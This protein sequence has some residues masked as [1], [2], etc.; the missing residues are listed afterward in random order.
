MVTQH[1]LKAPQFRPAPACRQRGRAPGRCTRLHAISI[2]LWGL[3]V[4]ILGKSIKP[5]TAASARRC[6][7][8]PPCVAVC[9]AVAV[10]QCPVCCQTK[11]ERL[12]IPSQFTPSRARGHRSVGVPR[13]AM[14]MR[15]T[16]TATC[17]RPR[18]ASPRRQ[19]LL[20]GPR[21]QRCAPQ[22]ETH[23]EIENVIEI[24]R[25]RSSPPPRSTAATT[26]RWH[27]QPA[28]SGR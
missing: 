2:N 20:S 26:P 15:S 1:V 7:C 5:A 10:W 17:G 24:V 14:P 25:R 27:R 11:A 19:R 3:I 21:S 9:V 22:R 13:E 28:Y 16:A 12:F 23:R 8:L 4:A 18:A 6:A